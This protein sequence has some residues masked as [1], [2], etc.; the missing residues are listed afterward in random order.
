ME[1]KKISI[2][3]NYLLLLVFT[4][5]L[6]GC[7]NYFEP[8][9]TEP[10]T[11][12]TETNMSYDLRSLPKPKEKIV[13][14]VY[15]F[16]DQTGQYKPSSTGAN[17]STAVTQGATSILLRAL[18]E[19]KWFTPIERE[20]LS[21]L[22][23]E[24]KIIRSS[25]ANF[26][27]QAG[28]DQTTLPPLLFAGVLLEGGI[29]S[30]D[31]NILTGGTGLKYFGAGASGQ[32]RQDRVT[33]Y[34]RAISTQNGRVLKTVY[35]SKTILSQMVDVGLI[36]FVE[37]KRLLEFETGYSSN[38]PPELCVTEAIEK[39]VHSLIIEGI[40]EGLWELEHPED[41]NSSQITAY[42]EEK[43]E[44]K[45]VD[46]F[47]FKRIKPRT[48]AIGF[49][50]GGQ[51]YQGDYSNGSSKAL[52]EVFVTNPIS[53]SFDMGL[54]LGTGTLADKK[55]FSAKTTYIGLNGKFYML[56]STQFSPYI[57]GALDATHIKSEDRFGDQ[58]SLEKDWVASLSIGLGMEYRFW[59]KMGLNAI[60]DYN[61][62]MTDDIDGVS[63][64]NI[65]DYFWAFRFG[66]SFYPG[67]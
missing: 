23:N 44:N 64:G 7:A 50:T 20:G 27:E 58:I 62:L 67:F 21:N 11:L 48:L 37:F 24:R 47:G 43:Q 33:I 28:I 6:S 26:E 54:R 14:A 13:T 38:E 57:I 32:Y 5:G 53:N 18:E 51:Q 49:N 15:K 63:K 34:L 46:Y 30:Y 52:Y 2:R 4:L 22:L 35:T 25:R 3:I 12:G 60:F 40:L 59:D 65:N 16:R 19:S 56:P 31:S 42:L 39:A 55:Y 10:A 41:I 36:R 8:M 9:K 1:M 17:W 29:I 61:Y 45:K 66:F